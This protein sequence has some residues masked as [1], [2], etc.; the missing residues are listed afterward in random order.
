MIQKHHKIGYLRKDLAR[1]SDLRWVAQA[2]GEMVDG[3]ICNSAALAA[4]MTSVEPG[5]LEKPT[6]QLLVLGTMLDGYDNGA[7][8]L[9]FEKMLE[10]N[11]GWAKITILIP[12]SMGAIPMTKLVPTSVRNPVRIVRGMFESLADQVVDFDLIYCPFAYADSWLAILTNKYN[13]WPSMDKGATLVIGLM[14]SI[15]APVSIEIASQLALKTTRIPNRF[16]APTSKFTVQAQEM[17]SARGH[18]PANLAVAYDHAT[19]L[20]E[21]LPTIKALC[22]SAPN[23]D[24][25]IEDYR[26]WGIKSIIKS[27]VDEADFYIALPRNLAVRMSTGTVYRIENDLASGEPYK[28]TFAAETFASY[29][30]ADSHWT[31]RVFW[32]GRAWESGLDRLYNNTI[33]A[34]LDKFGIGGDAQ[35][36][37]FVDKIDGGSENARRLKNAMT[38]GDRYSPTRDE[39]LL[40]DFVDRRDESAILALVKKDPKLLDS[41]NEDRLPLLVMLGMRNMPETMAKAIALGANPQARDGGERPILVELAGRGNRNVVQVILDAGVPVDCQDALG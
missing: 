10:K 12:E 22:T 9:L 18:K 41:F 36:S 24:V 1:L 8:W 23:V 7:W 33:G 11:A 26:L 4:W 34:Q 5:L 29:P 16:Y 38:G 2:P 31:D 39:R 15:D 25:E 17:V 32:A 40:F 28:L 3:F 19:N 27:S 35:L 37:E 13:A 21:I 20:T 30:P 14:E 6:L